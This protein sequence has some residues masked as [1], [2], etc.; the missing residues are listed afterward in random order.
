MSQL[1]NITSS[2]KPSLFALLKYPTHVVNLS[3]ISLIFF[4]WN[5]YL[6]ASVFDCP[7]S[8]GHEQA[9][10]TASF[11]CGMTGYIDIFNDVLGK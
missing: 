8:L 11:S 3:D 1:K 5:S 10:Y 4:I 2:G 7:Y 9:C 6:L